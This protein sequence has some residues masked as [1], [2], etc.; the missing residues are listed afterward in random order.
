MR[1]EVK[2]IAI[3]NGGMY[4]IIHHIENVNGKDILVE[5]SHVNINPADPDSPTHVEFGK[6][7]GTDK[8]PPMP[9]E[10]IFGQ[11]VLIAEGHRAEAVKEL[12]NIKKERDN[13]SLKASD[14]EKQLKQTIVERNIAL[15]ELQKERA[16]KP[17]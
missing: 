17:V 16:K 8:Y 10:D 2:K 11:A 1:Q 5:Q 4:A 9:I 13:I 14:L 6:I 15:A 3:E 12:N 7:D